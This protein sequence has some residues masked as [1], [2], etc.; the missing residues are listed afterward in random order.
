MLMRAATTAVRL[1]KGVALVALFAVLTPGDTQAQGGV[2]FV[3][4]DKSSLAWWQLNPHLNHLWAT[5][6]TEEP[7]WQP[8][9]DRSA[10]WNVDN[11]KLPKNY[12]RYS[13]TMEKVVPLFPRGPVTPV[14]PD[15][16][17][18][19]EIIANDTVNWRGV[20]GTVNVRSNTLITGLKMRDEFASKAV[21]HSQKFP[22]IRFRIDSLTN[23]QRGDTMRANA[24]GALLLHGIDA[25]MTVP[26][27]AWR[28]AGGLRVLAQLEM[29]P[30]DL[31]E[32]YKMSKFNLGLGVGTGIWKK[33]HFGV[34]VV[35][36]PATATPN[37]P[38]KE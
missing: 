25:P 34:D 21:L 30:S 12:V 33:L 19:G 2:R 18:S 13:N 31:V 26:V 36:R 7:S 1:S 20:H 35:L 14:C 11:S 28:E 29:P 10:G 6:C 3:V 8:G 38:D 32:K 37:A 27:K 23:V 5:T 4:D 22:Q 15:D 24:V 17:V 16:A 9:D